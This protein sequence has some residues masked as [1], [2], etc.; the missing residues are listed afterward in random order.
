MSRALSTP[1][2]DRRGAVPQLPEQP[3]PRRRLRRPWGRTLLLYG[4]LLPGGLIFAAVFVNAVLSAVKPGS[5]VLASTTHW[6]PSRW[7][8]SNFELPFRQAPFARYYLNSVL[9]GVAVTV[10]NVVTCTLA[11]YS[12][13]K[14]GYR[15]R[16]ALFLMV[17]ATTMIPL[18]V[19]YVPLYAL[20]FKLGW[21]NSFAG[22]IVPAGTSAFGILLMRQSIDGLPNEILDA[23][24]MDGAGELR[25]LARIVMPMMT[26]PMAALALFVFMTNWDSHLW[27]LLVG[28]DDA[29]RTL[30]VGLAAMQ[31]DNLGS[32]G[33]PMMMAAAVLAL[34]P[35]LVLFVLLQRKFV[36]GVTMTAEIK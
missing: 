5:E 19:I 15:G 33:I 20:I 1:R 36:E 8:W 3:L 2:T 6:L 26:S 14:F 27:P 22:L 10:L 30:P 16:N 23:A 24:R 18:E 7:I 29:H 31:A 35:T 11:G 34:L 9:V 12:F 25:I 17:L 13:A 32:A 28:S 21:V 4:V